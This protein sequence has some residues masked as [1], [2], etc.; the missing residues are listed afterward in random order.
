MLFAQK[1]LCKL[2]KLHVVI[3]SCVFVG[4]SDDHAQT[5]KEC[6]TATNGSKT[7]ETLL[8]GHDGDLAQV[9]I[10]LHLSVE[11]VGS[12]A[13]HSQVDLV[14]PEASRRLSHPVVGP[15]RVL[16]TMQVLVVF[17]GCKALLKNSRVQHWVQCVT[18]HGQGIN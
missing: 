5:P 17:D 18:G 10:V 3:D 9:A 12:G 13:L 4:C 16:G 11:H 2:S 8:D 7:C 14:L 15:A 1:L 6:S